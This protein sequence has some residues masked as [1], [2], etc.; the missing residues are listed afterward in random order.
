VTSGRHAK[1][2][3]FGLAKLTRST[4][5]SA[6]GHAQDTRATAAAPAAPTA[7]AEPEQLT[8]PGAPPLAPDELLA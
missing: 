5:V 7:T 8:S 3:D 4:A 2:L 1:I 6:V